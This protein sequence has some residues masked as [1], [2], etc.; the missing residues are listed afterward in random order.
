MAA[1]GTE[2]TRVAILS[3]SVSTLHLGLRCE[4]WVYCYD[5]DRVSRICC[6]VLEALT[7]QG[8]GLKLNRSV[9]TPLL[10]YMVARAIQ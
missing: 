6:F 1:G 9:K 10:G 7:E 5:K 4:L 8:R 3:F 2:K